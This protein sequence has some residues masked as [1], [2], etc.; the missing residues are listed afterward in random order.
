M[1]R[2]AAFLVLLALSTAVSAQAY[3]GIPERFF[4]LVAKGQTS[5]A[6]EFLYS[7]NRWVD[8]KGDQVTNLKGELA[9]LN[10]LVG[11]YV[12]HELVVEQKVGQRYAHLVYLVGFE[13]QPLRFEIRVYRPGD[14][15]RFQGV[16][17][18]AR[19]IEDID[20]QANERLTR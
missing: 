16:S 4:A 2:L 8:S 9:K 14:E 13:R 20:K 7:T 18:D 10:A 19:L 3:G 17:F 1:K 6:I 12:Y 5:E 11:K 15:W